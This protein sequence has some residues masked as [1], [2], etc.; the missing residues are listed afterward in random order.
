MS[1]ELAIIGGP[2]TVTLEDEHVFSWPIIT[3][4]DEGAA[5]EVLRAGTMSDT[6][7]TKQFEDEFADWQGSAYTLG[8][9]SGTASLLGAMYGVGVGVGDEV[10]GPSVTYWAAILPCLSLGATP[11]F[12]DIQPDSL[13]IDPES[14]E[15]RIS[16]HTKAVVVV[17]NYGHPADMDEIVEIAHAHDIAV[18]EDVSHAHGG[19][20]KGRKLG[21]IGDVGAMSLM[22][23]KSFPVGEGGILAT[24]D[25]EI[26]ER[27]VA[28]GHYTR[29]GEDLERDEL[30]QFGGLPFGGQ[31]HRMHQISAA[32]GRVQLKHYDDRMAEIQEAMGYF[33]ELL[34]DVSG[35]SI[36]HPEHEDSTMGGW[37]SPKG[38]YDAEKLDG[39]SVERFAEAVTAEGSTCLPG[40][41][42]ALHTH[43]L[44]QKADVY[45]H[46]KPTRIANAH[47][48]VRESEGDLP[49]A[50]G[51]QEHCFT[52]PWFK[53]YEPEVIEQHADAYR[54]VVEHRHELLDTGGEPAAATRVND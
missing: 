37:Y 34:D 28:F 44:L 39:L 30:A 21:T 38:L 20:Y 6:G 49:V 15:D 3:E 4:E 17:H 13:C 14:F 27:A 18:I 31:K 2:K 8:F 35:I 5:L 36:H 22:S 1:D 54:K 16:E 46:G 41:N 42:Y 26:Y 10:I 29:H 52:I 43:P 19:L 12:A 40:C 51:I 25:R 32:V 45:G 24:D 11:V 50:E 9:S 47:R 48:D 53:R 33:W 7:I 23:R